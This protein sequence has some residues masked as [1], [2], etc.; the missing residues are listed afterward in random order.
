MIALAVVIIAALFVGALIHAGDWAGS[1]V[2]AIGAFLLVTTL[3]VSWSLMYL[4]HRRKMAEIHA[5]RLDAL[6]NWRRVHRHLPW[7]RYCNACGLH[8]HNLP[9]VKAHEG[10]VCYAYQ[11]WMEAGQPERPAWSVTVTPGG[12]VGAVDTLTDEIET[13]PEGR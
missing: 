3:V 9:E 11:A 4:H 13:E 2:L 7:P 1:Q 12:G 8:V 10:S 6:G 5:L